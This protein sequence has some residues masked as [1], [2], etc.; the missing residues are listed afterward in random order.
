[1]LKRQASGIT[2][3]D[4][5]KSFVPL[6]VAFYTALLVLFSVAVRYGDTEAEEAANDANAVAAGTCSP[7]SCVFPPS[8]TPPL[9][10]YPACMH[11]H[12]VSPALGGGV[13]AV[14]SSTGPLSTFVRS[15]ALIANL[16]SFPALSALVGT[17]AQR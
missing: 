1:M 12:A 16:A 7:S 2:T 13:W 4:N 9:S 14:K 8:P 5:N 3:I 10:R 17:A 6:A 15:R 11:I